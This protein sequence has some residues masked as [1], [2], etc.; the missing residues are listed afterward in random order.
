MFQIAERLV[1]WDQ[2][3]IAWRTVHLK[4]VERII[5]GHVIGTQG[6]PWKCLA[7]AWMRFFFPALW[8]TGTR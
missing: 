1:D 6:R 5:G 3:L 7:G 4:L 2:R 8:D